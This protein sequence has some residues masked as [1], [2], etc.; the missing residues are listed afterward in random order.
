VGAALITI[1]NQTAGTHP[2][3]GQV[4]LT[5]RTPRSLQV[6]LAIGRARLPQAWAPH[7]LGT[8]LPFWV[9]ERPR[10]RRVLPLLRRYERLR[11]WC[12]PRLLRIP[13]AMAIVQD[14]LAQLEAALEVLA[15]EA[16]ASSSRQASGDSHA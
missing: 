10:W 8:T 9:Q 6:T 16:Q 7:A 11:L 5:W 14:E 13:E 12:H 15:P 4:F 3:R 2:Q 1:G